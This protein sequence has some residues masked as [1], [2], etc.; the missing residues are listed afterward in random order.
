VL[1]CGVDELLLPEPVPDAAPAADEHNKNRLHLDLDASG[2][3]VNPLP[4]RRERVDAKVGRL[5]E[6][7]ATVQRV[8]AEPGLDHYAVVLQDPEGNEFCVH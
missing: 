1:G 7:G 8:L 6:A 4:V 2:G 5:V 3:R